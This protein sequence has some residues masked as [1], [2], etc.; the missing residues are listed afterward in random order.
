MEG[1]EA[2]V[3]ASSGHAAQF[4]L[5]YTLLSSGDHFL[6]SQFL[7]GGSITQFRHSFSKF[8]WNS[9]FFDPR[10]PIS[11][12]RALI[13]PVKT[14][15][16]FCESIANP[17]GSI[18][19]L[20]KLSTLAKEFGIVLIVDNTLASPYL[21]RPI[22]WG[23]DIVVESTTKWLSGQGSAMGGVVVESGRFDYSGAAF[24]HEESK[25]PGLTEPEPA[26]RGYLL[27][28]GLQERNLTLRSV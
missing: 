11:E 18:T 6:A 21:C 7:Y 17:G 13:D 24:G 5:F 23:A 15:A 9:T 4:L 2:A 12:L 8:G 3:L 14:K 16:I 22:E 10:K 25:Y 1:G 26:Y 20:S 28:V 27:V 19:D